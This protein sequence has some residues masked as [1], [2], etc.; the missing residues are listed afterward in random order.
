MEEKEVGGYRE[1]IA[2]PKMGP[3]MLIA[4]SLIL[5]VRTAK[6]PPHCNEKLCNIELQEEVDFA[7]YLANR[8][9]TTLVHKYESI[10]PTTKK[11]WYNYEE[12]IPK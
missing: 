10:F 3:S 8:A 12:D 7:V 11:P 5:A 6:W 1:E 9:L 4:T 2:W